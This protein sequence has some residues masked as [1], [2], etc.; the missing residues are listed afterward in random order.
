MTSNPRVSRSSLDRGVVA[1]ECI[2][3]GP[4][5]YQRVSHYRE[6]LC[7]THST[8]LMRRSGVSGSGVFTLRKFGANVRLLEFVGPILVTDAHRVALGQ[9]DIDEFLQIS[10]HEYLGPS[11]GL[12]DFVNHSCEPNCGLNFTD[13]GI[14]LTTLRR[15]D[16]G[17][18]ISFDYATTQNAYPYRFHCH[19]GSL[20][21]RGEIGD[22]D[23]LPVA[24]KWHY[25][26]LGVLPPWLAQR[27]PRRR[28]S[29][30]QLLKQRV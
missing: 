25:H 15:L 6:G 8:I 16:A 2:A 20:S 9:S 29:S 24:L 21:C 23:E 27:L 28:R 26:D 3:S 4:L 12:D 17:E 22:F 5:I 18:E 10:A 1:G 14:Y 13:N 19:C 30:A 11:G 7:V